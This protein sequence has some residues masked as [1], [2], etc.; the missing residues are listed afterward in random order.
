MQVFIL[1]A[2]TIAEDT[3]VAV[4]LSM[5]GAKIYSLLCSLTVPD[6]PQDRLYLDL[7]DDQD[8]QLKPVVITEWFYFCRQNQAVL[9]AFS[10]AA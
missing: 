6:R 8:F 7:V 1:R 5:F 10:K 9:R 3:Q 2:N 4:F